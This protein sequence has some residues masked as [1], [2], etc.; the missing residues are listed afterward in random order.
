MEFFSKDTKFDFMGLRRY[1]LILSSAVIVI[2]LLAL[3]FRGLNWGLD[4]TGGT[5]VEATYAES[6]EITT[7][8]DQ[9]RTAG[10]DD[11]VVQYFGTAR[12][13]QIR[14]P[15][16][17]DASDAIGASAKV[18]DALHDAF[19]ENLVQTADSD[20]Q[21]CA[22]A[23]STE[24]SPCHVQMR[25]VEFVGPQVGDE[26][27]NDGGI[28]MLIA[29][30][31]ILLYV[32]FRF[33][34]K[35]SVAS[36]TALVH[37]VLVTVGI[38]ALFQ[39]EFSLPVLA[40]VLAVIGYSLNDTIVV[41]DRIRENFRKMRRGDSVEVMNVSINQT[42]RRTVLTSVT[43]LIVVLTLLLFG[44]EVI[45]GFSI[46]LFIGV[47]VGTYSSIFVASPVVLQL[48]ISRDDMLAVKKEGAELD[49]IP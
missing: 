29:L 49:A 8:R 10:I 16:S 41:F 33:E 20:V 31:C 22:K 40:A 32:T 30:G 47:I 42:L 7:V 19:G 44:G 1:A 13:I 38:F 5:M 28:A 23:G 43:T 14:L 34:W 9:L 45:R 3:V 27:A 35:F 21:Q 48:G 11:A 6:V 24:T 18:M 37:D 39:F 15:A 26:L 2:G 17:E 25:R 4:F 12:D 36:V 46:A